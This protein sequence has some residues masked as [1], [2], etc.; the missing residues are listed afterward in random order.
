[1]MSVELQLT[2]FYLPQYI[3]FPYHVPQLRLPQI[4]RNHAGQA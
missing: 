3:L 2:G 4:R 1:M